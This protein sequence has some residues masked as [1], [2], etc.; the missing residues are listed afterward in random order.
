MS[1]TDTITV[2]G[3]NNSTQQHS[4]EGTR[5]E[6]QR[7][8]AH[9]GTYL[10]LHGFG[11]REP[12]HRGVYCAEALHAAKQVDWVEAGQVPQR[13]TAKR[14]H[15]FMRGMYCHEGAHLQDVRLCDGANCVRD[16]VTLRDGILRA[17]HALH[18]ET[19]WKQLIE[20]K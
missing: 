2:T 14:L 9:T 7:T 8:D 15:A 10:L 13:P 19:V 17:Q 20:L 16:A 12:D 3:H 4:D 18:K 5:N 6:V 1:H 11:A